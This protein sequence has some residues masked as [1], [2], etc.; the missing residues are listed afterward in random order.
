MRFVA[1]P[2]G[3]INPAA[4]D[5]PPLSDWSEFDDLLRSPEWPTVDALNALRRDP[6][7]PRFVAQTRELESEQL[8]YE[9]RIGERSEIATRE[10]N[11]HDLLNA[12]I[13]LRYPALK[14]ALNRRQMK[15]IAIAGPKDR[16]R[17]QCA[18]THFDEAGI[19]VVV[20]DRALMRA[21]DVHD[22]F[23]LFW[24]RRDAWV[25]GDARAIVFGHALLEHALCTGQL[26][27]GKALVVAAHGGDMDAAMEFVAR[28]VAN[29]RLLRDPQ[30]LRP[31]P[32][33]GI[34]GWSA[35]T[36]SPS[37]YATAACFQPLR[38]SRTYPAPADASL[39]ASASDAL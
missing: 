11:W 22:W 25:Y 6:S 38:S 17:A 15:E 5:K 7:T 35:G 4:F 19:L 31:L 37:F 27:C 18:L 14:L 1:P 9:S 33:S 24:T 12:L 29:G 28:R 39:D 16:T 23:D 34:P 30:E 10:N 26:L 8:H 13:W 20:R 2:R 32:I 3:Q 21:W 36:N